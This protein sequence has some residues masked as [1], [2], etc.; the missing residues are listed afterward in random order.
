MPRSLL[1]DEALALANTTA[2]GVDLPP[3]VL[4]ALRCLHDEAPLQLRP[5]LPYLHQALRSKGWRPMLC[6][7]GDAKR[8]AIFQTGDDRRSEKIFEEEA[9]PGRD[10]TII[11]TLAAFRGAGPNVSWTA[12][13]A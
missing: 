13:P 4:V 9:S 10:G 8:T 11:Q 2:D 5:D 6:D 7:G 12:S 1:A 3:T